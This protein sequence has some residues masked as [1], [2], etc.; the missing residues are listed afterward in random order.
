MKKIVLI[1]LLIAGVLTIYGGEIDDFRFA[2]GL[3]SDQNYSL[4]RT[5]LQQFL[6]RYPDSTLHNNARFLL[7]SILLQQQQ[8]REAEEHFRILYSTTT[9]PVIRPDIYL[10]LAQCYFFTG[11]TTESHSLLT[12][13]LREFRQHR[14][15]WKAYFFLGRVEQQRGN[16]RV[17][18]NNL[19]NA[20]AL[21]ND[22]QIRVARV[23]ALIA[24]DETEEVTALLEGYIA[25]GVRN[26]H[27]YQM[28]V[29]FL[30]DLLRRGEYETV[31]SFAYDYIPVN[32]HYYDDYLLVLGEAKYELG[33]YNSALERLNLLSRERERGKYLQALC[34]MNLGENDTAERLFTDLSRNA[35]N[36]EI[37]TNSFFF[38]ASMRGRDDIQA[39][40]NMLEQFIRENPGHPFIGAAHY[41]IA[42]NHFRENRFTQALTGFNNALT[43]GIREEFEERARY[44]R[45]ESHFQLRNHNEALESFRGY[46]DRY[47]TGSFADEALFK[48]GLHY[49]ERDDF[50]NALVQF[51]RI[52][53]EFPAS[54]RVSMALFYQGEIFAQ[55][56]QY[57]IALSKY[58]EALPGFEDKG[59]V[60][61]RKA[62]VNFL[63]GNYDSSLA[64]LTNVP[65][66]AD[67]L[68]EKHIIT[69]NVHFARRNYL[70]AL[71]SFDAAT[72]QST[73]DAQ[74]EDAIL[75]QA[76]TLYQLR[77]YREATA[78]YR[79]LH[80]RAP[81]EQYLLMAAAAAF[82]AEDYR[83]AIEHYQKFVNDYPYSRDYHQAR[84]HIADSYYNLRDY[85]TAARR[86]QDLIRPDMERR[87]LLNSLNGLEWSSLQSERVDFVS[88]INE[89]IRPDSPT[90]FTLMLYDRKLHYYFSQRSWNEVIN[91]VRF[92]TQL[93]PE[94]ENLYNYRRMA[95]I[96]HTN[97]NQF[98]D[99]E[100]IFSD[101]TRERR[102]PQVL[103]AWARL[104]L[105]RGERQSALTRMKEA[106]QLTNE[107][108]IWLDMLTLSA[109]LN[110]PQFRQGYD[111]YLA[112]ARGAEREQA[113]LLLVRW[114]LQNNRYDEAS[115][116]ITTLLESSYEPVRA[117]AQ[118]YRGLHLFKTGEVNA[119]I[120]ELL[121][122]RYLFPRIEDVRL[123]AEMLAIEAYMQINDR[124]NA[125]KLL[126]AIQSSL[127]PE[128][129]TNLRRLVE[130]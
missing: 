22:W 71:R 123:D 115:R 52:S 53:T 65:D 20:A 108:Q 41:Q 90:S 112:F 88:M 110:D 109:E 106:T 19:N 118:Y 61:I 99:A 32:S 7:A 35:V 11:Q 12:R 78:L 126:D 130:G 125:R 25:E 30:N 97:L 27:L 94:N 76:R 96:A 48:L 49:Y 56:K 72:R 14:S 55:G 81:N 68:F 62:Q 38:L 116:T 129:R 47:P 124:E 3:Y 89:V 8:Y 2:L 45:G 64:N 91:S 13:F 23:E 39:A 117:R 44:L 73:T 111:R 84:Q 1:A 54:E 120:P 33:Q 98:N 50:P 128:Q 107:S 122:V 17:A 83:T 70:Q 87:I 86:Y 101:L 77:E 31:L 100:R 57:D 59:L 75:R 85:E 119:A 42:L 113:M 105:A 46:L 24:L 40:N 63:Q 18:L 103:Y 34:Y 4:A 58:Q 43:I 121:R 29:L 92:L 26:E 127:T 79:R 9:D 6:N 37:R 5:E 80:E 21:S 74:W 67:L 66:R 28:I 93:S 16:Y 36:V 104:D 51:S 10:G 15:V 102:D 60:W 95:A 82:T 114:N 69:G